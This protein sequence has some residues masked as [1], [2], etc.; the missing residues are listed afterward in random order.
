MAYQ[1]AATGRPPVQESYGGLDP[2]SAN[3]GLSNSARGEGTTT[4][5]VAVKLRFFN[6]V[7][8]AY[9]IL[10]HSLPIVINPIRLAL[11]LKSP[12]RI[13]LEAIVGILALSMLITEARVPILAEKI[14]ALF[15]KCSVGNVQ[16]I[17]LDL[18]RGRVVALFIM[19]WAFG[20]INH[21][22]MH[23]SSHSGNESVIESDPTTMMDDDV[24]QAVIVNA[25]NSS[26]VLNETMS[27]TDDML[28]SINSTP[29]YNNSSSDNTFIRTIIWCIL[30]SPTMWI[31]L[32]LLSYTIYVIK[33]YPSYADAREFAHVQDGSSSSGSRPLSPT[34]ARSWVSTIPD[35]SSIASVAGAA[36]YQSVDNPIRMNV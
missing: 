20:T 1:S 31:L 11:L 22:N 33:E 30:L 25:T 27:S 2:D 12:T 34:S 26:D 24:Q 4:S 13:V 17:D 23:K 10:F 18:A 32:A 5:E 14:L 35:F 15:R 19:V 28:G 21:L 7:T 8:C 3:I 6:C 29:G 16:L 36:G 9:L